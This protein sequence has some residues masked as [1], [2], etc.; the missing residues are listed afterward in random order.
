MKFNPGPPQADKSYSRMIDQILRTAVDASASDVHL[1]A[2]SPPLYRI[3]SQIQPSQ[4]P[5]LSAEEC[6]TSP[7]H[8]SAIVAGPNSKP[9]AMPTSHYEIPGLGR[10]RINA[11]FQR[12][13][14]ALSIRIITK[15]I[16]PLA[17]LL[18]PEIVAKLTS[19]PRGLILVTGPDRQR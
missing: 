15:T 16:P 2:G 10:F 7:K 1:H 17:E 4:F 13:T 11:H 8:C 5:A 6:A 14:V 12:K 18:L 3:H 9:T 19:T